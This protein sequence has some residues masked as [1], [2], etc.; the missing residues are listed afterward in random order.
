M[1][2]ET[3]NVFT[4]TNV[5]P[6]YVVD[7]TL[8]RARTEDGS[9]IRVTATNSTDLS[10]VTDALGTTEDADTDPTVIGLLKNISS[11]NSTDLS[12]VTDTLG[13]TED[14]STDNTVIGLLKSIAS[15]LQ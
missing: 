11:T 10:P 13:T 5:L 6:K 1:S 12:P 3:A 4:N 15:K 7:E 8:K 2:G 14:L 9:A